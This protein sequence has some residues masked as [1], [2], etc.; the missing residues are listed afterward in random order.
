MLDQLRGGVGGAG[1][2]LE[3]LTGPAGNGKRD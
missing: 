1:G 3:Y 2:L